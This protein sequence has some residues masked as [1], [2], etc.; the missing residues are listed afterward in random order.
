MYFVLKKYSALARGMRRRDPRERRAYPVRIVVR[1]AEGATRFD[2][3]QTEVGT[4]VEQDG[5]GEQGGEEYRPDEHV[6][7][8]TGTPSEARG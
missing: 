1:A 2:G 5:K 7:A 6:P 8:R 4:D 3:G